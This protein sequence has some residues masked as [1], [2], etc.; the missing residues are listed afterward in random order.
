MQLNVS[1]RTH[2]M[3]HILV[4]F[5]SSVLTV[6]LRSFEDLKICDL[7]S[8]S[9]H[10]VTIINAFILFCQC[11]ITIVNVIF[12]YMLVKT[13]SGDHFLAYAVCDP[14]IR[15][16]KK[17]LAGMTGRRMMGRHRRPGTASHF[18]NAVGAPESI[19][20]SNS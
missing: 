10:C 1:S 19:G 7:C 20:S 17:M 4:L 16:K 11:K 6:L 8:S 3:F 12:S 9:I 15:L 14:E 18:I 5:H 13:P 2:D